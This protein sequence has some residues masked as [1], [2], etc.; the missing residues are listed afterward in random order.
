MAAGAA[1]ANRNVKFPMAFAWGLAD[2]MEKIMCDYSLH[3]VASRAA[4]QGETLVVSNFYGTATRGFA[5][6]EISSVAVCLRPGT[7]V[8]F[9]KDAYRRGIFFRRQIGA[10]MARFRQ[11]DLDDPAV[12]HD[13]LEFSNGETVKVNAL[14]IGQR[15]RIVQLP[16]DPKAEPTKPQ[17]VLHGAREVLTEDLA[18]C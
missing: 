14:I 18:D 3:C 15:V 17:V 16:A 5:S 2:I 13:A 10:R 1:D 9:E 12:H 7:E 4:E 6:P 11:V 8:A